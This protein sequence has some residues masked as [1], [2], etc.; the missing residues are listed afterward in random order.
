M[1]ERKKRTL[2]LMDTRARMRLDDG[3]IRIS[4]EDEADVLV[5]VQRVN[6]L[7]IEVA[8]QDFLAACMKIIST[9]GVVSLQTRSGK[10]SVVM[11]QAGEKGT[12]WASDLAQRIGRTTENWRYEEWL[13][14]QRL[15]AW[16][17][18]FKHR[19]VG[20]FNSCVARL[21]KYARFYCPKLDV[22]ES[23]QWLNQALASW[24]EGQIEVEGLQPVERVV[25]LR[26]NSLIE[27]LLPCLLVPLLWAYVRWA[28]ISKLS[29][30]I[31]TTAFFELKLRALVQPQFQRH[32]EALDYTYGP[33]FYTNSASTAIS[34]TRYR[35]LH[36]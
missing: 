18:V 24:L 6:R 27:A 7:V 31:S 35:I 19:Y 14:N 9:G 3:A 11:R 1:V 28:R 16:S 23:L 12:P 32:I 10:N 29:S 15:H 4:R 2:Y 30:F 26:G 33:H 36:P 22:E 21:K 34:D 8:D 20:D 25:W 5:P 13:R 17:M